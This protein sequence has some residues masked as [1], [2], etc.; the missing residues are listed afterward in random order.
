MDFETLV[1]KEEKIAFCKNI[2]T[3]RKRKNRTTEEAAI[4]STYR[5]RIVKN[6]LI[7][8]LIFVILHD[9]NFVGPRGLALPRATSS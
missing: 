8:D 4:M 1:G 7:D 2:K 3:K 5:I 6:F 9:N